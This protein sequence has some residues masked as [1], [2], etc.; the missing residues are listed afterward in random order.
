M[1]VACESPVKQGRW[2][3]RATAAICLLSFVVGVLLLYQHFAYK[4]EIYTGKQKELRDLT[5]GATRQIDAILRQ[6]MDSAEALA[7][8][9]SEGAVTKGNMLAH[10]E[11]MVAGNP[12]YY[13]GVI[14]FAP[15]AYDAGTRLYAPF[16]SKSGPRE[17]LR[18]QDVATV[19]DYTTQE[20]DWYGVALAKGNRW[21]EPFW[22]GASRAQVT[23]YSA[24]FYRIDRATGK[25]V[26]AGVVTV[27]LSMNR[28]RNIVESLDIG[29]SGFGALT[30]RDGN[31]LYHPTYEYVQGRRNIRDV[32]RERQD[33]DRLLMAD[34]AAAGEGGII[35]HVSATTGEESWLIFESVPISGWSLQ[36]TFIKND[37]DIDVAALR[38][39]MIQIL[40]SAIVFIGTLA[41]VLLRVDLNRPASVWLVTGVVSVLFVFGI[42]AIWDLALTYHSSA[43][44]PGVKVAD[45]ATLH[46]QISHY[47]NASLRTHQPEPIVI[48]TGIHIDAIELRGANDIS[49]TG[50]IWQKYPEDYPKELAKGIQFGR[51][52]SV[53]LEKTSAQPVAGGELIQWSFQADLRV[54]LDH[55]RYPLEVEKLPIQLL[56]LDLNDNQVLVPDLDSYKLT[57]PTLLPGLDR[58]V[59]IPGWKLT[60]TYFL[61][62]AV[63]RN[64]DFGIARN[65]DREV[66]PTLYY[67]VGVQRVFIDAFISNLT[68]LIVVSIILFSLALLSKVVQIG[69]LLSVS[70]A[71]FFVVVFSHL[72]I[73]K[74]I[75]AGEIFYLEYIYFVIYFT[76]I[77]VPMDAFRLALG[78]RSRF[79]ECHNG[80]LANA[81]YWP[82]VLGIFF[83][84]TAMK[85]Y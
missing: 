62:R 25:R 53:R 44:I 76:I 66:L 78:M 46:T 22:G 8:G 28:I 82:V 72:D 79:F 51:A 40:I 47:R 30:T 55:S 3:G 39:Q 48:A 17:D 23:T 54:E 85:F 36:N 58:A 52:K 65:S 12:N 64:T 63:D 15:Y 43:R 21:S 27:T 2:L 29:P 41:F 59:F 75:A 11:A 5:A 38:Q 20:H 57:T 84:I 45:K 60:E 13:G 68:P 50:R 81:L 69:N 33:N 42:G 4:H 56:P 14:A 1:S 80:L 70:V 74:T 34:K 32:A 31:Y 9:L 18:F 49:I 6:A 35:D 16:F 24:L 83:A 10:L 19:Y 37:L 7:N 61:L 73:R 77:L 71:V 67:M 26:P